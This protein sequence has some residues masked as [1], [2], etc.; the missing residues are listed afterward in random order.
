MC[1]ENFVKWRLQSIA[2]LAVLDLQSH[3][4]LQEACYISDLV[5]VC[6]SLI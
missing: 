1:K 4:L 5:C 3:V 2:D 6:G